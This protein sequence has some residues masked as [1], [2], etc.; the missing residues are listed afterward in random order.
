MIFASVGPPDDGEELEEA[1]ES[2]AA[3]DQDESEPDPITASL[4]EDAVAHFKEGQRLYQERLYLEAADA[5]RRSYE[6]KPSGMALYNESLAAEKACEPARALKVL[7]RYLALPDC[8]AQER[9]HCALERNSASRAAQK[10]RQVVGELD[11]VLEAGASIRGVEI[12][13]ELYALTSFPVYAEP[14]ELEIVVVGTKEGQRRRVVVDIVA[15]ERTAFIVPPF[16]DNGTTVRTVPETEP[17]G[18]GTTT[19]PRRDPELQ[20]QRLRYAFYGSLGATI[21]S[22]TALAVVGGLLLDA[23]RDWDRRC[24]GQCGMPGEMGGWEVG[25][26][27]YPHDIARRFDR[28]RPATTTLVIVTSAFA[29][30]T[31]T[32]ALFAF[33]DGK[34]TPQRA[35]TRAPK[36]GAQFT[37]NGLRVHW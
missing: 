16:P 28:L 19:G 36:P 3:A 8:S 21:A 24:T 23:N 32:L 25:D 33:T 35:S 20:K 2:Q 17:D 12:G 29:L 30:T 5:F 18:G 9:L 7:D 22:G 13:G 1:A 10:L 26:D 15:G 34:R 37:G 14:G 6:S 4:I 27:G 11:P 31:I